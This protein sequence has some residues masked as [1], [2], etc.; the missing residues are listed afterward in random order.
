MFL[1]PVFTVN[2]FFIDVQIPCSYSLHIIGRE[3]KH[4][5]LAYN[6]KYQIFM[7]EHLCIQDEIRELSFYLDI[8]QGRWSEIDMIELEA[9]FLA[10]F[11]AMFA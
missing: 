10:D 3:I 5:S 6:K 7:I 1:V 2:H 9:D 4:I 8:Y 11:P